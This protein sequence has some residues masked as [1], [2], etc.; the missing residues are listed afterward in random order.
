[1]SSKPLNMSPKSLKV[2][3]LSQKREASEVEVSNFSEVH[4]EG[5]EHFYMETLSNLALP[6][7]DKE[8]VLHLGTQYPNHMQ[9][10]VFLGG[11]PNGKNEAKIQV[12]TD[13][14]D[15]LLQQIEELGVEGKVEE[16][17]WK[18]KL[19]E[20]LKEERELPRSTTL[21]IES[22]AEHIQKKWKLV[23]CVEPF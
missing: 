20:Q 14:T 10:A 19:V 5:Q 23:K 15:V 11:W 21:K 7:E 17:Q 13:N 16:A 18:M 4:V 22:F 8:T 3:S 6:K 12:L 9:P 1:M 2:S